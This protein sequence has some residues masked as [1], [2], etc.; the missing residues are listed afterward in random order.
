MT[1]RKQ[2]K[3]RI[4]ARMA[5]TG[6]RYAAA[7][8]SLLGQQQPV[9]D[10]GWTLH[11]GCNPESAA[12]T[13]LL[14]HAGI[15][16]EG[17]TLDEPLLFG[18]SGGIGA[19]YILWEFKHDDSRVVTIGFTNEWQ[20]FSRASRKI[21][22]RLGLSVDE[23]ATGG[24]KGAA[25]RLDEHLGAGRPCLVWPDRYHLG[26][27]QLPAFMDGRGGHPVVAYASTADGVRID[28][29]NLE[30]LTVSRKDFDAARARV[31]SYRNT[32]LALTDRDVTIDEAALRE[33]VR[34][35]LREVCE[36]LSS[37]SDSFGLPA[38]RK[39]SRVLVDPRNAKSWP[40]VFADRA[41]L[42]GALLSVWEGVVPAGMTGGHHRGL[43]ADFLDRAAVVL[44]EPALT[45]QAGTWRE[46]AGRWHDLGEVALPVDVPAAERAR[47]LTATV[48]TSVGDGDVGAAD[49]AEA[50]AELWRLRTEFAK[51]PPF[52][53]DR[54][55]AIF[56]GM[57]T[58]LAELYEAETAAIAEL[59]AVIRD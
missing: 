6:E 3:A 27:W 34:A 41:G 28:D 7:R 19:G 52:D 13:A 58:R 12:W 37:T 39:W 44:G 35:G 32:L 43:F 5:K 23:H 42:F 22:R 46:I 48:T 9:V 16:A 33:A 29:R 26:Y 31:G 38:W 17:T 47:V 40:K 14:R 1:S 45:G 15:R 50:A 20:Y 4:R 11:G 36:H 59:A 30:P 49:R 8:A 53:E 55:R 10:H 21:V 24:A 25:T 2:L 57:S 51:R 18:I 54:I 56:D